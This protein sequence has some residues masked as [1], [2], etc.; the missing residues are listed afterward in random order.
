[1]RTPIIAGN[2]KMYK[3]PQEAVAFV[4]AIKDEL[5]KLKAARP[6]VSVV[7]ER[8]VLSSSPNRSI[9][10]TARTLVDAMAAWVSD[11]TNRSDTS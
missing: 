8:D 10:G 9:V 7:A 4:N 1:M 6:P 5:G 3:T 2:W 11:H